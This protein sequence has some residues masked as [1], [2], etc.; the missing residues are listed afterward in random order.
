MCDDITRG[1]TFNEQLL[2][3]TAQQGSRQEGRKV[4]KDFPQQW[5]DLLQRS[6]QFG[7][8]TAKANVA[9]FSIHFK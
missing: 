2:S 1:R 3:V 6:L 5:G 7:G 8:D 4:D 9:T